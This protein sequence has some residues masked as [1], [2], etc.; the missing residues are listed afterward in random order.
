MAC[1]DESNICLRLSSNRTVCV[2]LQRRVTVAEQ[3]FQKIVCMKSTVFQVS[4]SVTCARAGH[5]MG[6]WLC[7]PVAL[8]PDLL[9]ECSR[10]QMCKWVKTFLFYLVKAIRLVAA[11]RLHGDGNVYTFTGLRAFQFAFLLSQSLGV[12]RCPWPKQ[13]QWTYLQQLP[14][15]SF[16]VRLPSQLPLTFVLLACLLPLMSTLLVDPH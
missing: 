10:V 4:A 9:I 1:G 3:R 2:G 16:Q 7:K 11:P 14:S 12:S 5:V 8:G 13:L 15:P 6:P